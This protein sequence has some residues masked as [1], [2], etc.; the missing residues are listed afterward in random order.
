MNGRLRFELFMDLTSLRYA[1]R[2]YKRP[3]TLPTFHERSF[4]GCVRSCLPT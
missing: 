4:Q 1:V 3:C 2:S